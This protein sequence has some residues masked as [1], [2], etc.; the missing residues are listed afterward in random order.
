MTKKIW[1]LSFG[2]HSDAS[3]SKTRT[4][5]DALLQTIDLAVAAEELGLDGAAIRVHHYA[6]QFATPMPLLAAMAARTKRIELGTGV[7]DMRYENPLSLAEQAAST[8]L[9]SSGRLQLGISRGSQETARRGYETF[10]FTP[11]PGSNDTLMAQSHT[12][13]FREAIGGQPV[14]HSHRV[15]EG[16]SPDLNIQPESKGLASR[17]WWGS[18]TRASAVWTARQG[19]NLMS[20]TLLSENTGVPFH[21]LQAE[22]I[23]IFR[24]TWKS[25]GHSR[26]PRVA[27]A[28]SILPITTD[29]DRW[30][31]E[32][33]RTSRDETGVLNGSLSRFGKVYAGEPD[34]LVADLK[35]DTAISAAD[36]LILT[37]PNQLGVEH[38][39]HLLSTIMTRIAPAIG[40]RN[41]YAPEALTVDR[42]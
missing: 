5:R 32:G 42:P 31:F 36:T 38:N 21:E 16:A 40:W 28:R 14:A 3:G 17:I 2:H 20:S 8:D 27:V 33:E 13:R 30:Y 11:E 18:A 23:E 37:I 24:N 35:E 9:I 29:R 34:Q 7:I 26:T 41:G 15:T 39:V 25:A 22:Q 12:M 10:G 4:S 1:F 6:P 19:M